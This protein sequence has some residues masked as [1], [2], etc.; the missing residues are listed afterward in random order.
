M[1]RNAPEG[2]QITGQS[3]ELSQYFDLKSPADLFN[4]LLAKQNFILPD[5][6]EIYKRCSSKAFSVNVVLPILRLPVMTVIVADFS[7]LLRIPSRSFNSFSRS[8]NSMAFSLI[9]QI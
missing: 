2:I 3:V 5:N 4:K 7:D 1:I 6:K 8:M 9:R